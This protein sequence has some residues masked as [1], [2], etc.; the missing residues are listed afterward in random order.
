MTD[1][2]LIRAYISQGDA[3][4]LE[5]LIKKHMEGIHRFCFLIL[6]DS[7]EARDATQMTFI[8]AWKH[9]EE[10]DSTY[11][12]QS[13]LYTIAKR[14]ALDAVRK[15]RD[16]PLS[17][18][19]TQTLEDRADALMERTYG[20]EDIQ[21]SFERKRILAA[22]AQAPEDSRQIVSLHME[23][24]SLAQIAHILKRPANTVKSMYRRTLLQLKKQ[25]S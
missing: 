16:L 20:R 13:W 5:E 23:G 12:F 22:L 18:L 6:R 11:E 19:N 25:F 14:T 10:Y 4:A 7:D 1:R 21:D 24:Y 8:K 9:L 17:S 3:S 15:K 2:E